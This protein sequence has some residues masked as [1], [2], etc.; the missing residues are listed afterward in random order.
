VQWWLPALQSLSAAAR[1]GYAVKLET[2]AVGLSIAE[3][4]LWLIFS[5]ST[6]EQIVGLAFC[7]YHIFLLH[8]VPDRL[9]GGGLEYLQLIFLLFLAHPSVFEFLYSEEKRF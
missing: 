6:D 2:R 3:G 4:T 9:V 5:H 7:W 8:F 1:S